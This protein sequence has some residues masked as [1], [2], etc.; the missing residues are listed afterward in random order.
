MMDVREFIE[1][2]KDEVRGYLP[3]DMYQEKFPDLQ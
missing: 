3:D 1:K 2:M